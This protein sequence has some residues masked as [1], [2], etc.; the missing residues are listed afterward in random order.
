MITPMENLNALRAAADRLSDQFADLEQIHKF[1]A[2]TQR[3]LSNELDSAR[4]AAAASEHLRHEAH[5]ARE[6][7][8][9]DFKD[10][11]CLVVRNVDKLRGRKT[12][13]E[14]V[15][16][17]LDVDSIHAK[18]ICQNGGFNPE[19]VVGVDLAT[20]ETE[21]DA[22]RGELEVTSI[23]EALHAT[24]AKLVNQ[25]LEELLRAAARSIPAPSP[26]CAGCGLSH[27]DEPTVCLRKDGVVRCN[28]CAQRRRPH[29]DNVESQ[30]RACEDCGHRRGVHGT[31]GKC[32]SVG[33]EP[34]AC[35]A[36]P[37]M[38][39]TDPKTEPKT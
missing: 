25:A 3:D 14:H 16:D 27:G 10:F 23:R 1:D 39:S 31:D 32:W 38:Y 5:E 8:R 30:S 6:K 26:A 35:A 13:R 18:Q 20:V 19:E 21:L 11:R 9:R 12:R 34:C 24:T 22:A 36:G 33:G 17:F 37:D 7:I 4:R 29:P 15:R 28:D 2:V